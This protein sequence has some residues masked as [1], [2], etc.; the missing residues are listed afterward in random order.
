MDVSRYVFPKKVTVA[1]K[2]SVL[3]TYALS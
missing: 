2:Q 3:I 1:S